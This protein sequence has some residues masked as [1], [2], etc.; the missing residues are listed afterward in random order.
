MTDFSFIKLYKNDFASAQ[1]S[2][3]TNIVTM[4]YAGFIQQKTNETF[5]QKTN[6]SDGVVFVGGIKVELSYL[7]LK[8]SFLEFK[9]YFL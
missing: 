4:P 6:C 5:C 9:S 3:N 7:G 2:D 8:F 1:R